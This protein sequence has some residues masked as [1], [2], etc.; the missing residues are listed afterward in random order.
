LLEKRSCSKLK[1]RI[2]FKNLEK[3]YQDRQTNAKSRNLIIKFK[4]FQ[5]FFAGAL[6]QLI[7]LTQYAGNFEQ[8]RFSSNFEQL[9][10]LCNFEQLHS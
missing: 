6:S 3:N 10:F 5:L 2:A 1:K 7:F 9:R 8:L 4:D